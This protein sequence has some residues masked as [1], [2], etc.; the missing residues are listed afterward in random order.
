MIATRAGD[1]QCTRDVREPRRRQRRA[2]LR[3]RR[4]R[5]AERPRGARRAALPR[6]VRGRHRGPRS[7]AAPAHREHDVAHRSGG[8]RRRDGGG[9]VARRGGVRAA[10]PA[11]A[12]LR[13]DGG[14]RGAPL[15]RASPRQ[16]LPSAPRGAP[17]GAR[18]VLRRPARRA[19]ARHRRL[20]RE[21]RR[22]KTIGVALS[23][24]RDSLLCLWLARRYVD[25][26]FCADDAGVRDAKAAEM[27][28]AFFMP[29]RYSSPE[30][31][32]AAE[33]AARELSV[34]FVVSP[35]DDAFV[36][37]LEQI[38]KMLQPGEQLTAMSRQNVQAR[39]RAERM[40]TWSNSAAGLFLQ[41]SN[42]S[43]K[44]VGYTTIGGDME[45][46]LSVI[47]NVPKTVV[48]YLLDYLLETTRLGGHP[49]H[50]GE[51]R[52][53]RARGRPGG[54]EGPDAVRGARRVLRA[55]RG[56]EDAPR[57]RFRTP[58][59]RCSRRRT[60]RA[61]RRGR[62]S[63]RG[64]SPRRSTSGSRRRSRCTS[65]TWISIASARCSSRSC[66]GREWQRR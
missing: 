51:A 16:L 50:V 66:S 39:V 9:A 5:R 59:A 35:I 12:G 7:H 33:A 32:D 41:T 24:G 6:G 47:A 1:N 57:T 10:R 11:R 43:E 27:L 37:E 15:P 2:D 52:L 4:L 18:R 45:G 13:G 53:R 48:N 26:R 19:G 14:A 60:R 40:W 46:A 28:R 62:R 29:T 54:R 31:R 63:S 49:P 8:V 38:E 25:T 21:D 22:F 23:G 64:S 36:R 34:P 30:T 65:A 56:G 61:S 17:L 3:R 58:F 55:V 20:L 44:A 42:M